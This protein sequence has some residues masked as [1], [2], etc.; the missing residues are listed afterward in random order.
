[1]FTQSSKTSNIFQQR[2]PVINSSNKALLSDATILTVLDKDPA[3]DL[4]V[5]KSSLLVSTPHKRCVFGHSRGLLEDTDMEPTFLTVVIWQNSRHWLEFVV[6]PRVPYL[7]RATFRI[8]FI[9]SI[10]QVLHLLFREVEGYSK[11]L[12]YTVNNIC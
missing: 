2:I 3:V 11:I 10:A 7:D 9:S 6:V 12:P 4:S 1:M 5:V 8:S